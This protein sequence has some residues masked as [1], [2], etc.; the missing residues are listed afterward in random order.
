VTGA[1]RRAVRKQ[2]LAAVLETP[3]QEFT[4]P[5]G[6]LGFATYQRF[7]LAPF[8]PDDGSPSPFY[9][10]TAPEEAISFPLIQ[11]E[12]V[13]PHYRPNFNREALKR[14]KARAM[15]D[16]LVFVIATLRGR[17]EDITVNLAGPLLLNPSSRLGLQ[18]VLDSY[19]VRYPLVDSQSY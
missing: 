14:L 19:P 3:E 9:I 18:V 16:L 1:Q 8:R 5:E 17:V 15:A 13:L 11:P 4:F 6:L 7:S 10:L 2:D 12:R